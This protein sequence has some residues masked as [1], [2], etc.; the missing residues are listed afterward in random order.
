VIDL[1]L[2]GFLPHKKGRIKR[3]EQ[4]K[5]EERTIVFYES[6][7]RVIK[8]L[9]QLLQVLE[10]D[11]PVSISREITKMFEETYR[12]SLSEAIA[13]FTSKAIKG[14]FVVVVKGR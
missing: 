5:E 1:C 9:E 6:P 2:K 4:L 10:E 14:E 12:G 7:Y 3:L 11:R 13:Y 8:L